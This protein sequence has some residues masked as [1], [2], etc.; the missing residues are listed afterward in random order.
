MIR[1]PLGVRSYEMA[2]GADLPLI[3]ILVPDASLE[4]YARHRD[5]VFR[6]QPWQ[7]VP[8][9]DNPTNCAAG[10]GCTSPSIP[11]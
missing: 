8:E 6:E 7:L 5:A 1:P 4:V 2:G 9:V 3:V 11:R 10:P